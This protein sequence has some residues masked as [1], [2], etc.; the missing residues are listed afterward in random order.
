[1]TA[2]ELRLLQAL[3]L[4]DKIARSKLRIREWYEHWC[5]KVYVSFSGGKDSTVLLHLVREMYPD[6]PAV[7]ADTGLEF[8]EIRKFVARHK[9]VEI[10][11]PKI[12]FREVIEKYGYPVISKD[13]AKSI[14]ELRSAKSEKWRDSLL[15]GPILSDGTRGRMGKISEKWKYLIDAP[16]KIS[17]KCCHYIKKAP[18]IDYERKNG[19]AMILGTIAT[20][21]RRRQTQYLMY[22]CNAFTAKRPKSSPLG[23]WTEQDVLRYLV[24]KEVPYCPIYGDIIEMNGQ[25]RTTGEYRTGCVFCMFGAHLDKHENRF[26]RLQRTHPKLWDYCINTLKC[27]E[28]LD[29]IGVPYTSLFAEV[30][31]ASNIKDDLRREIEWGR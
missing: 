21:S 3:P 1:M 5:G 26:T 24:E 29:Y 22:G 2:D 15:N 14:E 19:R 12:G 30:E 4:E 10:V 18:L 23:F 16:F 20:E 17:A 9:N 28:V 27:G 6:V 11:R 7:F 8:P 25:L 13:Q 31:N